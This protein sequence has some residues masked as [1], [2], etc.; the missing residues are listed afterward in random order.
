VQALSMY[1]D[2]GATSYLCF[3]IEMQLRPPPRGG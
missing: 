1:D 3:Q 2:E